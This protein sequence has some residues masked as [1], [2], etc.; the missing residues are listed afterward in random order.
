MRSTGVLVR[1]R[2]LWLRQT[3]SSVCAPPCQMS[4][5]TPVCG[6]AVHVEDDVV[7]QR[8]QQLFPVPV[9][10]AMRVPDRV[11]VAGEPAQRAPLDVRKR[12][13][14]LALEFLEGSAAMIDL[15]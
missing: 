2:P 11:E 15:D 8:A 12:R 6:F 14:A 9:G 1:F 4:S 3:A 10:R 13:R 5:T 7:Q